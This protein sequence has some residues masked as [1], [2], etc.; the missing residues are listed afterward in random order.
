MLYKSS[1]S[2]SWL[3]KY[4]FARLCTEE[5]IKDNGHRHLLQYFVMPQM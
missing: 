4:T 5:T 2:E 3:G 1:L